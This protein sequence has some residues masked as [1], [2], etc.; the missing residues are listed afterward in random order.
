VPLLVIVIEAAFLVIIPPIFLSIALVLVVD[1][2]HHR[3]SMGF[4]RIGRVVQGAVE[5]GS[6]DKITYLVIVI[7]SLMIIVPAAY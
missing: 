1:V 6:Q 3:F 2:L 7:P 5:L 4:S